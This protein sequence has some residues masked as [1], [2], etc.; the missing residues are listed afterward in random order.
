[1]HTAK[2]GSSS[3][4]T[5]GEVATTIPTTK[6]E[7]GKITALDNAQEIYKLLHRPHTQQRRFH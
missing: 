5:T 4:V 1:M 2:R 7:M 6:I 3:N